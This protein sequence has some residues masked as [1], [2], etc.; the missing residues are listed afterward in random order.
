VFEHGETHAPGADDADPFFL[1]IR[2]DDQ[3]LLP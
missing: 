2:H 1:A 3:S